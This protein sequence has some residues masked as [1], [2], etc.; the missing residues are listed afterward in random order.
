[1]GS[2][3]GQRPDPDTLMREM[4]VVANN[5]ANSSTIGFRREGVVFFNEHELLRAANQVFR[6]GS[7]A[8]AGPAP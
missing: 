3:D 4:G 1:M 5:I 7:E 2:A 6:H 8:G